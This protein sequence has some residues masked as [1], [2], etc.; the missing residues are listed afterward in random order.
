VIEPYFFQSGPSTTGIIIYI[1]KPGKRSGGLSQMEVL[2][3]KTPKL[4]SATGFARNAIK[5]SRKRLT[6]YFYP[7][8]KKTTWL[9]FIYR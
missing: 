3:K 6:N 1:D 9:A 2:I 7:G 5:T 8:E 4:N